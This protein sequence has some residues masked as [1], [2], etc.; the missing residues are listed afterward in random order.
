MKKEVRFVAVLS[1]AAV[2]MSGCSSFSPEETAVSV[3]KDG[4][5]KAAV[6]EQLDQDYY[7]EDELKTSIDQAVAEFTEEYGEDSVSV[8]KY[9]TKERNVTLMMEYADADTYAKF[10]HVTFFTG[11]MVAAGGAGYD[12][13]TTF[14]SVEKGKVTDDAV[15]S[16]EVLN[17]YNYNVVILQESMGVEV[18]GNIVYVSSNV[19]VTGKK[20]AKV[21]EHS[22]DETETEAESGTESETETESETGM[23]SIAPNE[24]QEDTSESG[25]EGETETEDET[26]STTEAGEKE[27]QKKES[28]I[29]Y[30][31]YE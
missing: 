8:E 28:S 18:P 23:M 14:Q 31:I 7:K 19:E 17:S 6:I 21:L 26:E 24:D 29:A 1:A 10:N 9:E 5:I 12:F 20:S 11:D 3:G 13:D 15:S 2:M 4:S 27:E 16:D 22:Q 25:T 30:I